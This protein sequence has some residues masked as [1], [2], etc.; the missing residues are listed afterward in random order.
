MS[1]DKKGFPFTI[2]KALCKKCGICIKFCPRGVFDTNGNSP[3]VENPERC[4]Q[5]SLCFHRCPDFAIQV[6]E[7]R[8]SEVVHSHE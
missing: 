6:K 1:K 8:K 2:D 3:A 4:N 5:C 7:S